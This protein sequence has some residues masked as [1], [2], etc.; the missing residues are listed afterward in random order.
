MSRKFRAL[1][2]TVTIA[3]ALLLGGGAAALGSGGSGVS[4]LGGGASGCCK[5]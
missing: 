1:V 3:S 4:P 5:Q 2:A